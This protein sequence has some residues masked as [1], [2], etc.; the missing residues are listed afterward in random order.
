[1][2]VAVVIFKASNQ[3]KI[4]ENEM[5]IVLSNLPN[6]I[7]QNIETELPTLTVTIILQ[8]VFYFYHNQSKITNSCNIIQK[9]DFCQS[10]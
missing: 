6:L 7:I 8:F 9:N 3:W 4:G 10:K 2:A 5:F 1:M